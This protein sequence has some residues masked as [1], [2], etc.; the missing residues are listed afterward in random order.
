MPLAAKHACAQHGCPALVGR[1]ERYCPAHQRAEWKQQNARR[2]TKTER[3]YDA[4]WRRL[5]IAFLSQHPLC[6]CDDCAARGRQLLAEVVD[7]R[8]SIAER[9][10]LRLDWDNLRAMSKRCHDRR[11]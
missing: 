6:E 5:R 3:G 9:P 1:G 4:A 2:G 8:I 11:T 7:H 10:D